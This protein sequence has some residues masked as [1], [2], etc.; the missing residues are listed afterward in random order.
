MTRRKRKTQE[1]PRSAGLLSTR[2]P[3]IAR[4]AGPQ[5]G[6]TLLEMLVAVAILAV[7]A[8]MVPRSFLYARALINRSESWMEARIVAEAV[9]NGE[10]GGDLRPGIRRGT[11]DNRPWR[12]S[13][14]RNAILSAGTADPER[15]LLDVV[16]TVPVSSVETLTVETMRVGLAR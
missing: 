10:L 15:A 7:L 9:L 5:A 12:A 14:Q 16:I 1:G 4:S 6:F 13:I 11:I 3:P 2:Q 8:G